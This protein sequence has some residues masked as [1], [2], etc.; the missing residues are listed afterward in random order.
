MEVT[1]APPAAFQAGGAW[2][3]STLSDSWYS[4]QNPSSLA[5]T[6]SVPE[7]LQ[8]KPISGWNLPTNYQSVTV[9]PG[10]VTNITSFYTLAGT[11]TAPIMTWTNPAA[12]TYGAAL[13]TNQLNATANVPGS[14]AYTPANGSVLSAGTNTLSVIFTPADTVDYSSVTDRVSLVV[15]PASL[16]VTAA[17]RSKTYGQ[18][19][20]FGGTEFT[21]SGLVNGDTVTSVTLTSSGAAATAVVAGSPYAIVPS[22]AV[23]TGLNNYT[24]A[25][26]NGALAVSPAALTVTASNRS[27]T[28]GQTVV[29]A[30]TEFTFSGL[31]NSD[32]VNSVTLTSSGAAATATVAGSPYSIVPSAAVGT[33]LDNYTITYA[34]GTLTV[35]P[36]ALTCD[37]EQP[38]QDLRAVRDLCRNRIHVQW[39]AEQRH[40]DQCDFNQFGRGGGG[41]GGGF[42]V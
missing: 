32:T 34:N 15:S 10:Q 22:A 33:G 3:L 1:I 28:Y 41:D 21:P 8:F 14:F 6:S 5:V 37:R 26:A 36:A 13:T 23:G 4:T 16:T 9:V 38:Q 7:Q 12:I 2:K 31:L 29:F 30:G 19:V 11:N 39:T 27:K 17:N 25:Y 42:A 20:T 18:A 24:I 35:N 40:G